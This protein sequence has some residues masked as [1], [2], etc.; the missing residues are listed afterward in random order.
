MSS[1]RLGQYVST[2]KA[3]GSLLDTWRRSHWSAVGQTVR[4]S[5]RVPCS[6]EANFCFV[7]EMLRSYMANAE[8]ESDRESAA[9]RRAEHERARALGGG[10]SRLFR[11]PRRSTRGSF[12]DPPPP[13]ATGNDG[14]PG[15]L[16]A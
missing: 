15:V 3:L 14:S 10:P 9:R 5:E 4:S 2:R 11:H 6:P 12:A 7:V 16:S 13:P 1:W 8:S